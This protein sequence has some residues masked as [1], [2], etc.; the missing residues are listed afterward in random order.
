MRSNPNRIFLPSILT[1]EPVWATKASGISHD[2]SLRA[3]GAVVDSVGNIYILG[4]FT[5]SINFAE[6]LLL[7]AKRGLKI[8]FLQDLASMELLTG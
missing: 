1:G 7:Q 5:G 4:E 3:G 2:D 6:K 8:S